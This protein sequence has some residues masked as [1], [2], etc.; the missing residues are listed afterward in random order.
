MAVRRA[1]TQADVEALIDAKPLQQVTPLS[2]LRTQH[3]Q[4][5]RLLADGK[6]NEEVSLITGYSPIYISR[7]KTQDKAF[8][9]LIKHYEQQKGEVYIDFHARLAMLGL[10]SLEELQERLASSPGSFSNRELVE[11]CEMSFDRGGYGP[12]STVK[13]S[14]AVLT[15]EVLHALKAEASKRSLGNVR[16]ISQ[17]SLRPE[18]GDADSRESLEGLEVS[19]SEGERDQVPDFSRE[20]PKERGT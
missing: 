10:N 8:K 17:A 9:D 14:V 16:L 11:L 19:G 18:V 4:L 7:L 15:P 2:S 5:A 1:L 6:S 3:H 20:V 13:A 12:S